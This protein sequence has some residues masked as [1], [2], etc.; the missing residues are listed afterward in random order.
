MSDTPPP[1][2]PAKEN[3][4]QKVVVPIVAVLFIALISLVFWK[5][6]RDKD[7][8]EAQRVRIEIL[9][10][11][12]VGLR[13]QTQEQEKKI[14]ETQRTL[15]G[16]EVQLKNLRESFEK[17]QKVNAA[18]LADKNELGEALT[19]AEKNLAEANENLS[20]LSS[21]LADGEKNLS[22]SIEYGK[23]SLAQVNELNRRIE[24]QNGVILDL[25]KQIEVLL[26]KLNSIPVL[27]KE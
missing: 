25:N 12:N 20:Q 1:P 10:K 8:I 27:P 22:A 26:G 2:S 11:Q 5:G 23:K 16:Q 21:K 14:A 9:E 24:K 19:K 15:D 3:N 13:N 7:T 17:G 6:F 4:P 18:L